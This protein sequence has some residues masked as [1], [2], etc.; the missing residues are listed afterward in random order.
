MKTIIRFLL[1]VSIPAAALFFSAGCSPNDLSG[2]GTETSTKAVA[3][4]SLV[5]IGGAYAAQASV[6]MVRSSYNP[7]TEGTIADSFYGATDAQ[8]NFSI[9]PIDTGSY[10][11]QVTRSLDGTMLFKGAFRLV[12]GTNRLAVDTLRKPGGI[13]VTMPLDVTGGSI[14]F[15][16]S[17]MVF[18][19]VPQ[20]ISDGRISIPG[21]PSGTLP[22]LKYAASATPTE[23]II[24]ADTVRVTPEAFTK[25][26]AFDV[27]WSH[28]KRVVL[29]T[30]A[31]G[32]GVSGDVHGFPVLLRL[33]EANFFFSEARAN[34]EDIRF[35]NSFGA[36]LPYEIESWDAGL[37]RAEV[38]VTVDTVRGNS[39]D[40][41]IT[42]YWGGSPGIPVLSRSNPAAVFDTTLGFQGVWHMA[43]ATGAPLADATVNRFEGTPSD[44]TPES[45]AGAVGQAMRFNGT[46]S[47]FHIKNT[48]TGRLDFPGF[49]NYTLSAWVYADTLDNQFRQII[50]K[51]DYKYALQVHNINEWEFLE[52]LDGKGWEAVRSPATAKAWK[53]ITGV[54]AGQNQYLYIDGALVSSTIIAL[55][56]V[57]ASV[58]LDVFI[59]RQSDVASRYWK[60]GIDEVRADNV[61][62]SAEWIRLCYMNQKE[63]DALV[64]FK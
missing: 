52:F 48:A 58:S 47:C 27:N 32:A 25:V 21:V 20:A 3:K 31:A 35:V 37:K 13:I 42:M 56:T 54:R 29:N 33:T 17:T 2:T 60:G 61:S 12:K 24:L 53:H 44:T 55:D 62:R 28:S 9:G 8:G 57:L 46:S 30:S 10:N 6:R 34:G 49:G 16:G 1:F 7:I 38:W 59:G 15:E 40:Q 11:M 4:G 26:N 41:Y 43:S 51:S 19:V 39:S 64:E 45:A 14:Y 22:R 5:T 63:T 36:P 18:A 23:A 50:S